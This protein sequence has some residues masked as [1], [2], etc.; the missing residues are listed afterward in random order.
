MN[1]KIVEVVT[2]NNQKIIIECE[3]INVFDNDETGWYYVYDYFD[4]RSGSIH[5]CDHINDHDDNFIKKIIFYSS[6]R[7]RVNNNVK[8][9]VGVSYLRDDELEDLEV[10]PVYSRLKMLQMIKKAG[11]KGRTTGYNSR[12]IATHTSPI[13]E[14]NKRITKPDFKPTISLK[15]VY[16]MPTQQG[17]TWKLLEKIIQST[18]T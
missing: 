17:Y 10:S 8:D 11:I 13:I 3:N 14:F 12:G 9:L 18:S 15:E 4:W 7:D 6:E 5:T 2:N 1:D 16:D